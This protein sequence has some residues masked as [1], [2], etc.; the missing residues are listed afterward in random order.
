MSESYTMSDLMRCPSWPSVRPYAPSCRSLAPM[1]LALA[2]AVSAC[3]TP[4]TPSVSS[5][6][7]ERRA[8]DV[9]LIT[10]DTTRADRLEPY[11]AT[12]V[13]TPHLAA[14]AERG[15]LFE[16]AYAVAPITL[17]A[18]ASILTGLTPPIHGVR[19]N[20]SH[21]AAESLTTLAEILG[22]EGYRTAAFVSAAV[23]ERR[24]GL[25]QG[26]E[27]YDDDLSTSRERHPRVVADRPAEATV[28]AARAWLDEVSPDERLFLWVHLYD[29]HAVYSPPAPYRDQYAGRLYDGEIAYMDSQIGRLLQ[30]SRLRQAD[31]L[32]ITVV[33]DHG[34][35]LGEHGEQSHAILA[36]DSTL[37]VPWILSVRGGPTGIIHRPPVGQVDLVPSLLDLLDLPVP[38]GLSG[39]SLLPI[40]GSTHGADRSI[41]AETYLPFYTYGW[42]KL[43]VVRQGAWKYID[44]PEPELYDLSRDPWE[45]TNL[46]DQRE[47]MA[48]DLRRMLNESLET[49]GGGEKEASLELDNEAIE[50]LRSLGYISVGSGSTT[51]DR[52][53]PDPKTMVDLHVGLERSRRLLQDRLFP[54]AIT[55]TR[56]ILKKDPNNLAA[57]IDLA[58][59][60]EGAADLDGA[61]RTLER[62]L[63][64]EPRYSR[65][66]LLMAGLESRRQEPQKA[67]DLVETALELDPRGIEAMA[68][69][70]SLLAR[71]GRVQEVRD[72]LARALEQSPDHPRLLVAQARLIDIPNR[73]WDEAEAGLRQA[74]ARDPFLVP[75]YRQL[76]S[77]L[78]LSGRTPEA[79]DIYRL[80]LQKQP[81]DA[82][83]H[84]SLGVILARRS[85]GTDA[86]KHL[87][88]A[89][90][91]SETPRPELHVSLGSWLAEHGRVEEARLQFEAALSHD[92]DN[93]AARSNR[94]VAFYRLGRVDRAID[95]LRQVTEAHPDYADAANNLAAIEIDRGEWVAAETY[96]RRA[97][98][99]APDLP[100]AW[101]NLGV[102]LDEQGRIGPAEA[103]FA[104]SLE[105][106]A[107]YWQAKFNLGVLLAK[108]DRAGPAEALFLEVVDQVPA[109]AESHLRLGR[110]YA[111]AL[112]KP[113]LARRHWNVFLRAAP[114]H[115]AAA[116]V[117]AELEALPPRG[118]SGT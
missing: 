39:Q 69:R 32:A 70:A 30:H 66:Y 49:A 62:A 11:G 24:Y 100:E 15:I 9:V 81:D 117:R 88:E 35:S 106:A 71:L 111:G 56:T 92:P 76:G 84:G 94:A 103:A 29:P 14:L 13:A 5:V 20:G 102:A 43:R 41:Y 57:L 75:A 6:S 108:T 8:R 99:S 28:D 38:E 95:E 115:A 96:A 36:Y 77:V 27:T 86:E 89:L 82:D 79:E 65:L 16:R 22:S 59:A 18:H 17:V 55:Q 10:V 110:L 73:R 50:K 37:R 112:K 31:D 12:D 72:S 91:L 97:I 67:L 83:L 118:A 90:R 104:R 116:G 61:I 101:N 53:R 25:D 58:T 7:F 19:N 93:A 21:H 47:G 85:A 54:Q 80:G 105:L 114:G 51:T 40:L 87:K 107:D 74:I 45:L 63:S 4:E 78:E 42:A 2:M 64:L 46:H 98:K 113:D 34:E 33:G 68:T 3:S 23:L 26:F 109:Y 44:A 48:H 60:Q 52:D 1:A